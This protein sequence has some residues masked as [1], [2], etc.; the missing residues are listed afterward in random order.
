MIWKASSNQ[1]LFDLAIQLY[2]DISFVRKLM[3]DNNLNMNYQSNLNDEIYYEYNN[4]SQNTTQLILVNNNKTLATGFKNAEQPLPPV[5]QRSYNN[6]F[7]FD[8]D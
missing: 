2:G 1:T 5:I 7:N 3:E 6:D 8:F 4:N